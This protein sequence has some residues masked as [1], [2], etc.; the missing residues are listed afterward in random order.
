MSDFSAGKWFEDADCRVSPMELSH[1]RQGFMCVRQGGDLIILPP[2]YQLHLR[3]YSDRICPKARPAH[4]VPK[5][6][7]V[8]Q[9]KI[10]SSII[11]SLCLS[12][13]FIQGPL[14][15]SIRFH[16][17][18]KPMGIQTA[19]VVPTVPFFHDTETTA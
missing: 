11:L 14:P 15:D 6:V 18:R 1:D 8:R 19:S 3:T 17:G 12:F 13:V 16:Y 10:L 4:L 5:H 2:E 9:G 7:A